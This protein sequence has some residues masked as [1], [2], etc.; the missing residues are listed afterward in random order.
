MKSQVSVS[1]SF[2]FLFSSFY[3]FIF[4][5]EKRRRFRLMGKKQSTRFSKPPVRRFF[6]F[7]PVPNGPI[8]YPVQNSNQIAIPSVSGS[9]GPTGRSGF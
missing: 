4:V 3:I 5:P 7:F 1:R 2:L 8:A 6:R 9:T